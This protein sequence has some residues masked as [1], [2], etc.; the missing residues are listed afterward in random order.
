MTDERMKNY[1]LRN[2][3]KHPGCNT[4]SLSS[5]LVPLEDVRNT[6]ADAIK[7][8]EVVNTS[9]DGESYEVTDLGA[10]SIRDYAIK[11]L[12]KHV[13]SLN[14]IMGADDFESGKMK[15]SFIYRPRVADALLYI[16]DHPDCLKGEV[17]SVLGGNGKSADSRINSL[18][19]NGLV[20]CTK[21]PEGRV[22]YMKL[23]N[24]GSDITDHI[25]TIESLMAFVGVM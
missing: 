25:Q 11:S 17:Y 18:V 22:I 8:G 19:E 12:E 20:V 23:T 21:G 4:K 5:P 13:E 7:A 14:L 15:S 3:A 10:E 24:L 1:V 9:K 16:R 2:I 6:I